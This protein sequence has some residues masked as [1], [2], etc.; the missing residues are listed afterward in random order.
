MF[1]HEDGRT[2]A[3]VD[4]DPSWGFTCEGSAD[5]D[6]PPTF[7]SFPTDANQTALT[8]DGDFSPAAL[9]GYT[10]FLTGVGVVVAGL[11]NILPAQ[12]YSLQKEF[13]EKQYPAIFNPEAV[14][15][16]YASQC[17]SNYLVTKTFQGRGGKDKYLYGCLSKA[18]MDPGL[19]KPA[20]SR[21]D[22][23]RAIDMGV[24]Y[25]L[26]HHPRARATCLQIKL[27]PVHK[28]IE[29]PCDAVVI[30]GKFAVSKFGG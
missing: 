2:C 20:L 3:F 13:Y 28:G 11:S 24:D 18:A 12:S 30:R 25:I 15:G 14:G 6:K 26:K 21:D 4:D 5:F 16:E 9:E 22:E 8:A 27:T 1:Q 7:T 10:L 23:Q 19:C 17:I 29:G